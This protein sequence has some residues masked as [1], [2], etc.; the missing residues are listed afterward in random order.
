[1]CKQL[2]ASPHARYGGHGAANIQRLHCWVTTH[3]DYASLMSKRCKGLGLNAFFTD[4]QTRTQTGFCGQ[5][6]W[7]PGQPCHTF[8][9]AGGGI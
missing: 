6:Y 4:F 1:M 2:T 9:E 3:V 7:G 8:M 5:F